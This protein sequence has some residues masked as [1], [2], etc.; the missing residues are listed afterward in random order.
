MRN[1]S[2]TLKARSEKTMA[3]Y[4]ATGAA[5]ADCN[6]EVVKVNDENVSRTKSC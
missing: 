1:N 3:E 5:A 4:I 2:N 6:A